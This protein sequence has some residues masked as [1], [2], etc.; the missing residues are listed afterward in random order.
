MPLR[1]CLASAALFSVA[2]AT[3]LSQNPPAPIVQPAQIV[4]PTPTDQPTQINQADVNALRAELNQRMKEID[5]LKRKLADEEAG[6]ARISRALDTGR[7]ETQRGTG[8]EDNNGL[9]V[10]AAATGGATTS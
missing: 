6:I 4:Q 3:A 2:A 1:S 8:G 5:A 9:P 7:L 10:G